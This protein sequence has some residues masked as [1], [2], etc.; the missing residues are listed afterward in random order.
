MGQVNGYRLFEICTLA[1]GRDLAAPGVVKMRAETNFCFMRTS[2][3]MEMGG[4][5]ERFIQLGGGDNH[6]L[7]QWGGPQRGAGKTKSLEHFESHLIHVI[8]VIQADALFLARRISCSTFLSTVRV[9]PYSRRLAC[10]MRLRIILL[11][12]LECF[13]SSPIKSWLT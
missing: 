7:W 12:L 9:C 4:F 6:P 1:E 10:A 3:F 13:F 11:L 5:N 2:D 8:H